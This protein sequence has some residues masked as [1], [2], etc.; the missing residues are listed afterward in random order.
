M[1]FSTISNIGKVRSENQDYY[2]NLELDKY[3]FFIVADG[4]GG[5]NGGE[6][7]SKLAAKYYIEYIK[8]SNIE[9]FSSIIDLQEEALQSANDKIYSLS[10]SYEQYANM[11][12]T[13]VCV[14][15]DY[16][17]KS[18]HITH[19]GD[20]RA[21]IYSEN[22]L[23][24]IT[25]DHSLVN[26]LIDSGSITEDEAKNFANKSTITRAVGVASKIK[27]ESRSLDMK[28][29]D[30]LLMVTDGLTNELSDTEIEAIIANNST[31]DKISSSLVDLAIRNGGHDNITV[32][33]ILI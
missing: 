19:I 5:Y 16:D 10:K 32:T 18:Y 2:G 14:C 21:Y 25:R 20:S 23:Q 33:T 28:E 17:K 12:T 22:K 26:D 11:G 13:A 4:M 9:D 24:L 29:S 6:L 3:S 30:I 31:A 8:N 1:K 7:A 15:V 27:P